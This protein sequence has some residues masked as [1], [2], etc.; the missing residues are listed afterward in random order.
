MDLSL[1]TAPSYDNG[2]IFTNTQRIDLIIK[3]FIHSN[4]ELIKAGPLAYLFIH[5]E[6]DG[7]DT[8]LVGSHIDS[9]YP[10]HFLEQTEDSIHG[11]VD[12]GVTNAILVDQALNANLPPNIVLCF[13]GDEEDESRGIAQA[14]RYIHRNID[15]FGTLNFAVILDVT[16]EGFDQTSFTIENYFGSSRNIGQLYLPNEASIRQLIE[17]CFPNAIYV[18]HE[19]A[20]ADDAWEV[21]EF[22]VACLSF[23]LPAAAHPHSRQSNLFECPL[24]QM[25]RKRSMREYGKALNDLLRF[26]S[27]RILRGTTK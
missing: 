11:T 14:I 17:D 27:V 10:T 15:R 22:D 9:A 2:Q 24:G 13:N 7:Q 8:I 26:L 16:F 23:C 6:H 4:Y 3:H 21:D 25:I 1:I 12:N 18:H 5:K 20:G 19:E